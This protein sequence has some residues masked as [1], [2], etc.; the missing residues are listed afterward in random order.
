M[1]ASHAHDNVKLLLSAVVFG[2]ATSEELQIVES[3]I[4]T[5]V[6][7]EE[8]LVEF[9][10]TVGML[11]VIAVPVNP[12]ADLKARVMQQ[13]ADQT[14][15]AESS[16]VKSRLHAVAGWRSKPAF[17][18]AAASLAAVAA[19]FVL[20]LPALNRAPEA[21]YHGPAP[22]TLQVQVAS[23]AK[24]SVRRVAMSVTGNRLHVV[25]LPAPAKGRAWQLWSVDE[26]GVSHSLALL[27]G[28]GVTS[29]PK[30]TMRVAL[31]NEPAGG[32][33]H[34]SSA[35]VVSASI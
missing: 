3:H 15:A 7:C 29:I 23:G 22:Q 16:P 34:P 8:Q 5:C 35:P 19:A 32:S 20:L 30:T 28:S 26:Q 27:G 2:T 17:F 31:T 1:N 13:I 12:P 14:S 6:V 10:E 25:G 24:E 4:D 21:V 11:H 33:V 18:G 9:R